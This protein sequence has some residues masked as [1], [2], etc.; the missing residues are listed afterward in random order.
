MTDTNVFDPAAILDPYPVYAQLRQAKG[1]VYFDDTIQTW[2]VAGYHAV[3]E[4][5]MEKSLSISFREAAPNIPEALVERRQTINAFL[6]EWMTFSDPPKHGKLRNAVSHGFRPKMVEALGQS[7]Q[8]SIDTL[9]KEVNG[10][11]PID[12]VNDLAYPLALG[13]ICDLL[14]MRPED[15]G[16]VQKW[17]WA[18]YAYMGD[19]MGSDADAVTT[20]EHTIKEIHNYFDETVARHERGKDSIMSLLIDAF[21]SGKMTRE[22]AVANYHFLIIA[23]QDTTVNLLGNAM[24]ALLKNPEQLMRLR[25][26][27]ELFN[28]AVEE[29][30]RYDGSTQFVI[31]F[32]PEA[33]TIAGHEIPAN[34][35]V[36]VFFGSANRDAA[37]FEEADVLK[38]DR[39]PN[40]HVAFG[41]GR[42]FCLG[43]TLARMEIRMVLRTLLDRYSHWEAAGEA[44]RRMLPSLR[45]FEYF[46]LVLKP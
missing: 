21:E 25:N 40:E 44:K 33:I 37:V 30:L 15:R 45:G 28:S 31:R 32:A 23:G 19:H 3:R 20:M 34:S 18:S 17:M 16:L 26:E 5:M 13:V 38:L 12:F 39:S 35:R 2:L 29:L 24:D 9:L 27:P 10:E 8:Q 7:I 36:L 41:Y 46:P 11:K 6:N 14:E 4:V 42:H 1:G 43:A 22:Q